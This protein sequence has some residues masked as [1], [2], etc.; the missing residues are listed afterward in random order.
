MGDKYRARWGYSL[1]LFL[2]LDFISCLHCVFERQ[3]ALVFG[4]NSI[5]AVRDHEFYI[6]RDVLLVEI[7]T[8]EVDQKSIQ[9]FFSRSSVKV[10]ATSVQ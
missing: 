10:F 4:S 2:G 8:L 7:V 9:P 6:Q 5:E 1:L 3:Q